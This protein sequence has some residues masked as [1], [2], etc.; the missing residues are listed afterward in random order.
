MGGRITSYAMDR[1]PQ[2]A[3]WGLFLLL[4]V[5]CTTTS[6]TV[7]PKGDIV[8]VKLR[9][10]PAR[11]L[12]EDMAGVPE[13]TPCPDSE[14]DCKRQ[15]ADLICSTANLRDEWV[16]ELRLDAT[17]GAILGPAASGELYHDA[18]DNRIAAEVS[19]DGDE[20]T[21]TGDG[22]AEL[23]DRFGAD[24]AV[25]RIRVVDDATGALEILSW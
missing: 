5:G 24:G 2:R 11:Q 23:L 3:P 15:G 19:R 14:D 21:L 22:A 1:A 20:L 6:A 25:V 17:T 9:D 13:P 10:E 16:C 4:A 12:F 7:R 18:A 8:Y